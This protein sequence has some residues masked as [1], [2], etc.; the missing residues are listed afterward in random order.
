MDL[1]LEGKGISNAVEMEPS[2]L[3]NFNESKEHLKRKLLRTSLEF[4]A[5][6][7]CFGEPGA[8]KILKGWVC[9]GVL[10]LHYT[11]SHFCGTGKKTVCIHSTPLSSLTMGHSVFVHSVFLSPG[12]LRRTPSL[13][14]EALFMLKP[15]RRGQGGKLGMEVWFGKGQN[16][17]RENRRVKGRTGGNEPPPQ[18]CTHSWVSKKYLIQELRVRKNLGEIGGHQSARHRITSMGREYFQCVLQKN[19]LLFLSFESH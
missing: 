12:S 6:G 13:L 19:L 17:I 7:F 14:A 9:P 8:Q 10:N 15:C 16:S 4:W 11:A 5:L 2:Q 18:S 1:P 3:H